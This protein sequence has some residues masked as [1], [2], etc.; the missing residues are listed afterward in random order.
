MVLH[1]VQLLISAILGG[2]DDVSFRIRMLSKASCVLSVELSNGLL[3]DA[4]M[5]PPKWQRTD[6]RRCFYQLES[7]TRGKSWLT[8]LGQLYLI[9]YSFFPGELTK[10][11]FLLWYCL[12]KGLEW[13]GVSSTC[14]W[15]GRG[16]HSESTG[17]NA[18]GDGCFEEAA[19]A[20][21]SLLFSIDYFVG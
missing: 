15:G 2:V 11:I 17:R 9:M 1:V 18:I 8:F 5:M 16:H 6:P 4:L 14:G 3:Q 20:Y 10:N 12:E 13:N 21:L 7:L 19:C